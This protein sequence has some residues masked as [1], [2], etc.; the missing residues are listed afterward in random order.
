MHSGIFQEDADNYVL[1]VKTPLFQQVP[2]GWQ[3]SLV[4]SPG[5]NE[6]TVHVTDAAVHSLKVSSACVYVTTY[7]QYR[8]KDTAD[9][10]KRM[11]RGNNGMHM[12]VHTLRNGTRP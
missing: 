5:F 8:E 7:E 9:F 11:Y 4:D 12:H 1:K 2:E 3:V 10:F 6:Y